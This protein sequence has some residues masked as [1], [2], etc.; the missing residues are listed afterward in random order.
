MLV[1]LATISFAQTRQHTINAIIGDESFVRLFNTLP[2]GDTDEQLRI[3]THLAY[4]E[5]MLRDKDVS[6]LNAQQQQKRAQVLEYLHRYWNNG[7]FP[8]N[9]EYP[10]ERRPCF[11]DKNGNICAVGYLI[12]M[13]AGRQVAEDINK[14]HQYDYI[15]DMNE[16]AVNAWA[17]EHGLTLEECAMIQPAYGGWPTR[18]DQMV[19]QPIKKSYGVSSGV[20]GG[21]NIG[22][23]LSNV[24]GRSSGQCRPISYVGFATGAAQV[25]LGITNIKKD[26]IDQTSSF[27]PNGKSYKP[28]NNLSYLNIAVGSATIVTSALNLYLNKK[29]KDKRNAFNLYSYPGMNQ[30]L[31]MGVSFVR[32]L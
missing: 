18:P 19:E 27:Y 9:L 24:T 17:D 14:D 23:M 4:V 13:T 3:Q 29:V 5:H 11:I 28:Q 25:I 7:V 12:E 16:P 22:V 31:N 30:E 6:H 10:G 1:A 20:L 26:E 32:S 2:D 15:V 8:S 21:V